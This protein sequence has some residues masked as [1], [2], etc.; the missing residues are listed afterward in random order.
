MPVNASLS[1]II[2]RFISSEPVIVPCLESCPSVNSTRLPLSSKKM[3][4]RHGGGVG[5]SLE[6]IPRIALGRVP[7][8][9]GE[10]APHAST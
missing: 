1:M 6:G 2:L 8:P 7:C 10:T 3:A 5:E 4:R 9:L